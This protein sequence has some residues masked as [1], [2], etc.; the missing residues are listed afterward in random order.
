MTP[1][2][3]IRKHCVKCV[4]SVFAPK[5]CKGDKMLDGTKCCPF[6]KYREGKRRPSVKTIYKF[7]LHCMGGDRDGVLECKTHRCF[8]YDYR[9][10]KNPA[11]ADKLKQVE[12]GANGHLIP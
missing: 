1:G 8:L 2:R 7:C 4:G 10:G 5:N 12:R 6:F 11:Y 9:L 3:A